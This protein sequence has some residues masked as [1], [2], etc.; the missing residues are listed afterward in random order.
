MY[1]DSTY[2]TRRTG[3]EGV[4][5]TLKPGHDLNYEADFPMNTIATASA[6]SII[7]APTL[8]DLSFGAQ[9][10]MAINVMNAETAPDMEDGYESA[11]KLA[12]L[13]SF[14]EPRTIPPFSKGD[15]R[16]SVATPFADEMRPMIDGEFIHISKEVNPSDKFAEQEITPKI[17][18]DS[19]ILGLATFEAANKA[20]FSTARDLARQIELSHGTPPPEYRNASF[21]IFVIA[22]NLSLATFLMS[23]QSILPF[24]AV[25]A[26]LFIGIGTIVNSMWIDSAQSRSDSLSRMTS[27]VRQKDLVIAATAHM[28]LLSSRNEI[29]HPGKPCPRPSLIPG[30]SA[31]A[32]SDP[33]ESKTKIVKEPDDFIGLEDILLK[34]L[35]VEVAENGE[36]EV[37]VTPSTSLHSDLLLLGE[38]IVG[39]GHLVMLGLEHGRRVIMLDGRSDIFPTGERW[40]EVPARHFLSDNAGLGEV[41]KAFE[42]VTQERIKLLGALD[43]I[44]GFVPRKGFDPGPG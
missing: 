2:S 12:R 7:A 4:K 21:P 43:D 18:L 17:I 1:N 22:S 6:G 41:L 37:R 3:V 25:G 30:M 34:Y 9:I 32:H 44:G 8:A 15:Y 26:A 5:K 19:A 27:A 38:R 14:R 33:Q 20:L 16:V 42:T 13:Y 23:D 29:P 40:V 24:V 31:I 39:A 10:G 28:G 36:R 11:R 35:V